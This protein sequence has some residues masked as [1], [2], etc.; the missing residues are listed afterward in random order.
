MSKSSVTLRR[1]R[2]IYAYYIEKFICAT[3]KV[4]GLV[5]RMRRHHAA[6]LKVQGSNLCSAHVK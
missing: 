6:L 5:V 2:C 1:A 3:S 4:E